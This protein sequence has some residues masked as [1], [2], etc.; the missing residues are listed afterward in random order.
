MRQDH[1]VD[2]R[3]RHRQFFP[4]AQPEQL[5]AL[6]QAAI[7]QDIGGARGNQVLGAGNGAGGAEELN[8]HRIDLPR[9]AMARQGFSCQSSGFPE[10]FDSHQA[11]SGYP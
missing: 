5:V 11:R 4:V 8:L 2:A 9:A 6:E 7:D 10:K 1:G 3:R